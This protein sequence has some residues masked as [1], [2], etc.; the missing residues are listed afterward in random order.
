MHAINEVIKANKLCNE[1]PL[2]FCNRG[3]CW[4]AHGGPR[5]VLNSLKSH[6]KFLLDRASCA[7]K[8]LT[9]FCVLS[10][11]QQAELLSLVGVAAALEALLDTDNVE[12]TPDTVAVFSS[13]L[14]ELANT[15]VPSFRFIREPKRFTIH[16]DLPALLDSESEEEEFEYN[17]PGPVSESLSTPTK[18]E[19][20]LKI[21]PAQ[22]DNSITTKILGVWQRRN[23]RRQRAVAPVT[24]TQ[25]PQ[26]PK[27]EHESTN[28]NSEESWRTWLKTRWGSA[29]PATVP[30][31]PTV[32]VRAT[33][34]I[35]SR[36][37]ATLVKIP[38]EPRKD[39]QSFVHQ[40][41]R[42]WTRFSRKK[43][44]IPGPVVESGGAAT[45]QD[46]EL[47]GLLQIPEVLTTPSDVSI[48]MN[49]PNFR[50]HIPTPSEFQMSP[51]QLYPS[52]NAQSNYRGDMGLLH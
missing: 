35:T 48:S 43:T 4:I 10:D 16:R 6:S 18:Q 44:G 30:T 39:L 24:V 20:E 37:R 8:R 13:T 34:T 38:R 12:V 29:S 23:A 22:T 27:S 7:A 33:W 31:P 50:P 5:V 15:P 9:Q 11:L 19:D 46:G 49:T 14:S 32:A 21:V 3:D 1:A 41:S 47:D 45:G 36:L 2:G 42:N 28:H 51:G 40:T 25:L 26:V 17:K 52:V